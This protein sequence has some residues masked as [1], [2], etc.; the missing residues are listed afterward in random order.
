M[1]TGSTCER[2]LKNQTVFIPPHLTLDALED[3]L[4][5]AYYG[6]IKE[7]RD[8]N[9]NCRGYALPSLCYSVLP[10]CRTPEKTNH[11]YFRNKAIEMEKMRL[12]QIE[13]ITTTATTTLATTTTESTTISTTSTTVTSK[14]T[15]VTA[16]ASSEKPRSK[17]SQKSRDKKNK[18]NGNVQV[19]HHL[20]SSLPPPPLDELVS[21]TAKSIENDDL[22]AEWEQSNRK[23]SRRFYNGKH[24]Y[25]EKRNS[26]TLPENVH[27]QYIPIGEAQPLSLSKSNQFEYIYPPTRSSENLRRICRNE[28]ELLENELCQKE[29]AIAKR[30]P[31]IGQILPLEDC[32]NL[33]EESDDCSSLGIAIDV[34]ENEHCYWENGAKYRGTIAVSESGKPCLTWARLMKEISDFPELAGQNYCR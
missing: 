3:T 31:A 13:Q 27:R 19:Q 16:T 28:C 11:Q 21:G 29:Y 33:P 24:N 6:V 23:R 2:F 1:Y 8:M 22:I 9:P 10:I 18:K 32:H 7:S 5:A 26:I 14:T 34:D 12:E 30:H 25:V 20:T 4:K 15:L 17:K